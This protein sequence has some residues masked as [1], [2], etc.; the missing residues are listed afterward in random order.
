[1]DGVLAIA[2]LRPMIP[3]RAPGPFQRPRWVYEEKIDG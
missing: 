2:S 3:A 1:M